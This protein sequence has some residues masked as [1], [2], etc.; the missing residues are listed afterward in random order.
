MILRLPKNTEESVYLWFAYY[1]EGIETILAHLV[2][3][4]CALPGFDPTELI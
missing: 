2:R 1:S 3:I 4:G